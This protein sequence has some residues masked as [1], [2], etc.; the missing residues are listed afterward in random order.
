[1][2]LFATVQRKKNGPHKQSLAFA[3]KKMESSK[4][5]M[6]ELRA[7]WATQSSNFPSILHLQDF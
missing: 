6:I 7:L 3:F 2:Y 5:P 1:M 4:H